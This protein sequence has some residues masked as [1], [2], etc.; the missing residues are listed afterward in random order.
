MCVKKQFLSSIFFFWTHCIVPKI[1]SFISRHVYSISLKS[2]IGSIFFYKQIFTF[3]TKTG[4]NSFL[5]F[6]LGHFKSVRSANRLIMFIW[7]LLRLATP[8]IDHIKIY[9]FCF[10]KVGVRVRSNA[11]VLWLIYLYHKAAPLIPVRIFRDDLANVFVHIYFI[12]HFSSQSNQKNLHPLLSCQQIF[13]LLQA[14]GGKLY[15]EKLF[16]KIYCLFRCE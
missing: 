12:R 5:F 16:G 13:Q 7:I 15:S 4:R 3:R 8:C 10:F 1:K 14:L 2:Y 9:N 6:L 11:F